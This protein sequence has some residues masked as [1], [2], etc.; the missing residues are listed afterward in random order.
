MQARIQTN[1]QVLFAPDIRSKKEKSM[2]H[3]IRAWIIRGGTSKGVY[4]KESDLPRDPLDRDRTI[5]AFS[6]RRISARSM[7]WAARTRSP[8]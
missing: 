1:M 6:A 2:P 5:L 8:T 7:D 3:P 4:L